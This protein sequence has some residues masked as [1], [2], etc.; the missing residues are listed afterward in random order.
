MQALLVEPDASPSAPPLVMIVDDEV[1]IRLVAADV[2]L[3]AGF[4][5]VEAASA[6]EA[7]ALL[8]AGAP[9]DLVVTDV[10]M[11]GVMD[12][13]AL[14]AHL[15]RLDPPLPVIVTSGHMGPHELLAAGADRWLPKPYSNGALVTT[16]ELA[17]GRTDA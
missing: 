7:A 2:L 9:V 8:A 1:L 14:V 15:K 5:V 13:L 6:D 12:G 4:R 11:P 3:D 16:V 17:L 10:R